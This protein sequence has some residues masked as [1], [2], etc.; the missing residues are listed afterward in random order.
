MNA[1][2][3][4]PNTPFDIVKFHSSFIDRI[5]QYTMFRTRDDGIKTL[6]DATQFLLPINI[7]PDKIVFI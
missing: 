6:A 4:I 2:I 5:D 1:K 3:A 7:K